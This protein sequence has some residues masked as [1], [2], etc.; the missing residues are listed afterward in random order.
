MLLVCDLDHTLVHVGERK[1]LSDKQLQDVQTV[2][3]K[4]AGLG[5]DHPQKSLFNF[6]STDGWLKIRPGAREMLKKLQQTFVLWL[7]T[8]GSRCCHGYSAL[9]DCCL[10]CAM[11][12][13]ASLAC[14]LHYMHR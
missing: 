14:V 3:N 1:K 11:S 9:H 12:C 13:Q 10:Y 7:C 4:E 2:L 5:D 8:N 6:Y